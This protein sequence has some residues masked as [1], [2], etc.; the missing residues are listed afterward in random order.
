MRRLLLLTLLLLTAPMALAQSSGD[1]YSSSELQ[2]LVGPIALYPDPLLANVL[3][4]STNPAEVR[5]ANDLAG[6]GKTSAQSPSDWDPGVRALV[7]YPDV[8][9]DMMSNPDWLQALGYA[10]SNQQSDVMKAVE[11]YR[12]QAYQAGNLQS[13]DQM[14]VTRE[15]DQ[16]CIQPANPD[17]IYV[18]QYDPDTVLV[19]QDS[20]GDNVVS[21]LIGFGVGVAASDLLWYNH[22]NWWGYGMTVGYWPGNRAGYGWYRPG[23]PVVNPY[24]PYAPITRRPIAGNGNTLRWNHGNVNIGNTINVNN[25]NSLYNKPRVGNA[26]SF[27]NVNATRANYNRTNYSKP[28]LPS[29]PRW[30]GANSGRV[31]YN[32]VGQRRPASTGLPTYRNDSGGGWRG[33]SGGGL[34]LERGSE[35]RASSLRGGSSFSRGGGFR[36]GRR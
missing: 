29:Q 17:V 1:L 14:D 11:Q 3:A 2:Q 36:G 12:E 4:A 9:S 31:D 26:P 10:V 20:Y 13:S 33:S 7:D 24:R 19:Q 30:N 28:A 21:G 22:C 8:L 5:Q 15:E 6:Q 27:N 35:A 34:Q 23:V 16:I 25:R 18:P 32:N